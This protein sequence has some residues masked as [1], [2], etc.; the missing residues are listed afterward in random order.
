M[1][2]FQPIIKK[3]NNLNIFEFFHLILKNYIF[4]FLYL[5]ITTSFFYFY[6]SKDFEKVVSSNKYYNYKFTNN[7]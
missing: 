7:I 2:L 3:D 5:L 1:K 4:I 6:I